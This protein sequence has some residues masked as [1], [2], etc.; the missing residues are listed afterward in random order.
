MHEIFYL[1]FLNHQLTLFGTLF[2]NLIFFRNKFKFAKIFKFESHSA[3]YPN[4]PK[5]LFFMIEQYKKLFL[6]GFRPN[7]SPSLTPFFKVLS[8]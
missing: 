4:T 1:S 8:L 5:E 2:H 6:L 7:S 3:H